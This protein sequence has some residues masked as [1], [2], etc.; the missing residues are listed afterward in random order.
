MLLMGVICTLTQPGCTKNTVSEAMVGQSPFSDQK[1]YDHLGGRGMV[2]R[3]RNSHSPHEHS[4]ILGGGVFI[5]IGFVPYHEY[6]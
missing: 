5:E 6:H 2:Y 3:P 4:T 1:F